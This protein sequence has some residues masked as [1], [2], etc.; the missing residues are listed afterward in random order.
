MASSKAIADSGREG[1]PIKLKRT[2]LNY[3][4]KVF[5]NLEETLNYGEPLYFNS[6]KTLV[7]GDSQATSVDNLPVVK[8]KPR[9]QA[10]KETLTEFATE[11]FDKSTTIYDKN[12]I[13]QFI[14]DDLVIISDG[15]NIPKQHKV[16]KL[17]SKIKS[18]LLSYFDK[19]DNSGI[20]RFR[21]QNDQILYSKEKNWPV[22][23]INKDDTYY[24]INTN[25]ISDISSIQQDSNSPGCYKI[26]IED[27]KSEYN[28]CASLYIP[29]ASLSSNSTIRDLKNAYGRISQIQ[30]FD[31]Y[32]IV[33]FIK[34][35]DTS[36]QLSFVGG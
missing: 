21:D 30:T 25:N 32:I 7:I 29:A 9:N 31:N 28:P 1:L 35:P 23:T 5:S 26:T 14:N 19:R 8:F 33:C 34:K 2:D 12:N 27:M 13:V 24:M 6:D 16:I 4:N 22:V 20:T 17:F 18:Q 15:K 36:F 11:S 3:D 10:D